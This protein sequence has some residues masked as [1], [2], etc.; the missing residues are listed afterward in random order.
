M[1]FARTDAHRNIIQKI[2][3]TDSLGA[4]V[5]L[6]PGT[7]E[8]IRK[9]FEDALVQTGNDAEF[10]KEWEGVVLEG[11][12]FEQMFT[13]KEILEDV[14]VYTDWRPEILSMFKRLAYEAPR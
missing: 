5:A 8:S 1:Q 2:N 12:V 7:P 4:A 6:P 11:N 14:K 10:K 3:S 9:I 13:G